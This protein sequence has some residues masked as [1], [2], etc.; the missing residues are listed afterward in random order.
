MKLFSVTVLA[1]ILISFCL[2]HAETDISS[3]LTPLQRLTNSEAWLDVGKTYL[4][5]KKMKNAEACLLRTVEF[6]PMG[7]AAGEAREILNSRFGMS[8]VYLPDQVYLRYLQKA[9]S[10]S[11]PDIRI[12][13]YSMALEA[14]ESPDICLDLARLYL[15][16]GEP[17]QTRIFVNRAIQDGWDKNKLDF[18]LQEYV[19]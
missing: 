8:M 16:R 17:E 14:K 15:K 11:D 3:A 13:F 2:L 4:G 19:R 6:Y 9:Q 1:G 12:K 18:R 7:K 5:L 10:S